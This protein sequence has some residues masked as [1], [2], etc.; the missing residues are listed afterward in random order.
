[1]SIIIYR[2]R[3][4]AYIRGD[5]PAS[6]ELELL[7]KYKWID[8]DDLTIEIDMYQNKCMYLGMVLASERL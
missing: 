8:P 4:R 6:I 2:K 7:Q 1:M 3:N 5:I